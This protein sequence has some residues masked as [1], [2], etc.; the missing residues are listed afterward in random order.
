MLLKLSIITEGLQ[1]TLAMKGDQQRLE[2]H[3]PAA[4]AFLLVPQSGMANPPLPETYQVFV[5]PQ[6]IEEG[7]QALDK[8][9]REVYFWNLK[10]SHEKVTMTDKDRREHEA[11][12]NCYMCQID[13][14]RQLV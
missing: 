13:L 9:A 5:G 12:T 8:L 2:K 10:N 7:L 3:V 4:F 6:C 11:A 14:S 1:T